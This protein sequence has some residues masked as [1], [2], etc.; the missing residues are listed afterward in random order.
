MAQQP[1]W[2]KASSLSRIHDHKYIT[3]FF[4]NGGL[5]SVVSIVTCC[6]LDSL[7]FERLWE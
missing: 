4:I 1:Q 5:D 6:W 2:F 3:L 7:E